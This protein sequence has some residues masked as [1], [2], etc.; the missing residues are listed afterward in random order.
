MDM[1]WAQLIGGEDSHYSVVAEEVEWL[2]TNMEQSRGGEFL[3]SV[4]KYWKAECVLVTTRQ[5]HR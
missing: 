1:L 4:F 5:V 3:H 2:A